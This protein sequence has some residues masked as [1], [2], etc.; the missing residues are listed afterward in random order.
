MKKLQL[1]LTIVLA[2]ILSLSMAACRHDPS[3]NDPTTPVDPNTISNIALTGAKTSFSFGEAFNVDSLV[4]T[5][6]LSDGTEKTLS[7]SDYTVVSEDYNAMKVG[8][9]QITVSAAGTDISKTYDVTV[10]P[11]D[12]LKVLMIGNSFADDAINYAYE[13][14][15]NAGIPQE[16]IV[17]AD[18]YI[19]GCVL[20]THWQNAK[21]N[22]PAYRFGLE[23]EGWFDGSSYTNWTME[24]AIKYT[25]WDFITFQ[26]GSSA[27]GDPS[28][29]GNL[30]NL[31]NY[32]YDIATDEE[33][34][35][36]ANP[37]VKFVWHQ[38]WAYQQG[39]TAAHFSKYN[40]DQMTMYNAIVTCMKNFVVDKDFVAIIPNGTA[41]QNARSSFIGDTFSRD[42][43]NHLSYSAGR[44]I[45]AMG[46]VGTLTGRDMSQ[47]TWTPT[48]SGFNYPMT[49]E[50]ILVCKESY[51]NATA[52]PFEITKS[53]YPPVPMDLST[54]FEG[55]GTEQNPYLIQ[56]A[57]DMLALSRY[58]K[59]KSFTDT[60][61]YFK[62]TADIDLSAENWIPICS[63]NESGWVAEANSFNANF[64]GNGKTVTFTGTYT[65]DTWAKGLFSAVG[66]YVHDLTLRGSIHI[67]K[68]R[69]GSLASMAMSGAKIENITSYV[70]ITAGNNQVGGIVGYIASNNVMIT[71]CVNYGTITGRELVG[72]IVGGSW[73]NVTYTDCANHGAITATGTKAGGI[74]GEKFPVA[75]L[76]NCSNSGVIMAGSIAASADVGSADAYVGYLIGYEKK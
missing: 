3:T 75:T 45:A 76:T 48:A 7:S 24:Q 67:E 50:E 71:N 1:F 54:M 16:N 2:T 56:S 6:T 25:D 37:N 23:K 19:G 14:A 15:K 33:N 8:T 73:T 63:S 38:T 68:G 39:T 66:G 49:A 55:K 40:F 70:D 59:A 36:N 4:V 30:Q 31:M 12:R 52:N 69:V 47:I 32:V 43:H 17:I 35:P 42:E 53:K 60:N 28:S 57:A 20:D 11:A 51:A 29:F 41:V 26:Q 13:I 27:S 10:A 21:T 22:A 74:A 61:T 58:T 72:G 34:N 5:A 46:L 18:I 62:L 64:D 44:Y 9:Y 65:G